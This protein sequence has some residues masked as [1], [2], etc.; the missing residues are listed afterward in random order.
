MT[1]QLSRQTATLGAAAR[2]VAATAK[3]D[4]WQ[5]ADAMTTLRAI[6]NLLAA[7]ARLG[8]PV[9]ATLAPAQNAVAE[10]RRLVQNSP[11]PGDRAEDWA[12][13]NMRVA[14]KLW[15]DEQRQRPFG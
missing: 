9:D 5:P 2:Q 10:M 7:L 11:R 4:G 6:D 13:R 12:H 1:S 14:E 15:L 3:A 8:S